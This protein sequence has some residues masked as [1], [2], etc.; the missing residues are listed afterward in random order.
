MRRLEVE[1]EEKLSPGLKVGVLLE[2]M[3][4]Q[5]TESLMTR[6]P[7]PKIVDEPTRRRRTSSRRTSGYI[8]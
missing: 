3:P 2:M 5:M 7:D 4:S 8:I 1:Y 6:L